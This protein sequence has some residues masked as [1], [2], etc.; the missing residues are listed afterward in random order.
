LDIIGVIRVLNY[1]IVAMQLVVLTNDSLKEELLSNGVQS[2][3]ELIWI[4]SIQETLNYPGAFAFIDLLFEN[5]SSR[6]EILKQLQSSIVIINSVDHTLQEINA[7][8]VR[9][10]GWNSFLKSSLIE[11]AAANEIKQKAEIVW[12]QFN[13]KFEWLPDEAGFI[14]PRI[15]CSI[16]NEAYISLEENVSSKEDINTAMKLGTNYPY[17]PFEWGQQIGLHK[18]AGLLEKLS[19]HQ[20]RYRPSSLLLQQAG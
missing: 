10:N 18:V 3:A 1:V 9:I 11:A 16:I 5:N 13:K 14:T 7:S 17:G 15:I 6:I 12:A 2:G 8:F 19:Q 4:Q 20:A